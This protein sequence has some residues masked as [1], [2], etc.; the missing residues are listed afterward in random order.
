MTRPLLCVFGNGD[1]IVPRDT[2][3]FPYHQVGSAQKGLLE[4][5]TSDIT[6]A[7]ADLFVSRECH[8]RVFAPLSAWLGEQ[9]Q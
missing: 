6:M 4:V 8:E 7:H 3:T 1:G 9:A 2:A 5:G